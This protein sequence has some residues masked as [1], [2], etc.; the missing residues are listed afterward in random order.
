[1]FLIFFK[2]LISRQQHA[3]IKKHSTVTNLLQCTHDWAV[4]GGM[5]SVDAVYIG[6]ARAFDSVVHSKLIFKLRTFGISENLL[7]WIAAFLNERFQCVVIE[8]CNSEWLPVLS[9]IPKGTVLGPVLFILFI[10]DIGV[11]CSGSV[12][13][14][15]FSD[16]MKLYS[17]IDT[18]L[19]KFSLQSAL[20][21]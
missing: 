3:L 16:D 10:D 15:L 13:H 18:N 2:G 17:T 20:Y 9:G 11:I 21:R 7:N 19:D 6:F 12:T 4:H 14:K 5:H 1:L 8:H